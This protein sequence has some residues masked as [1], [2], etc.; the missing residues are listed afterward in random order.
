MKKIRPQKQQVKTFDSQFYLVFIPFLIFIVIVVTCFPYWF[1]RPNFSGID[2]TDKGQIGD[3]IGGITGPFIAIAGAILTFF[4]FWV[5]FKAN[6][7]QKLDLKTERFENKFYELLSLHKSNVSEAVI[8]NLD[9]RRSFTAMFYE[10]R[11]CYHIVQ[12]LKEKRLKSNK[13]RKEIQK[14]K[15]IDVL[16]FSYMIFFYGIG[17][18]SEKHFDRG[19]T[20]TQKEFFSDIKSFIEKEIHRPYEKF[21]KKKPDAKYYML[22]IIGTEA[23]LYFYPFDGHVSKLS[24][25]YRH[26][27]QTARFVVDQEFLDHQQKY[28]YLKTLR[29]QLSNFEQL[30]L[31]YNAVAWFE[32]Q[33]KDLFIEYRLIKNIP[34]PLADFGT[35]PE[36]RYKTEIE[37]YSAKGI[38]LFEWN[39]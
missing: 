11:L 37:Q 6:E 12:H 31:Y 35:P 13:L 18:N 38:K 25:Y 23:E 39:K 5:Q 7:Q 32:D 16:E 33:W 24:H 22:K 21:L 9:G 29:A 3:T 15:E 10:L 34:I 36:I 19:L 14:I 30:L 17:P 8:G 20:K 27:F 2:F 28:G 1:T 4:A 26:L